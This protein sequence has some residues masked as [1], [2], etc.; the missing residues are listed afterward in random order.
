MKMIARFLKGAQ[1]VCCAGGGYGRQFKAWQGVTQ[2]WSLSP[3]IFNLMVDAVVW[4]WLKNLLHTEVVVNG[5]DEEVH[6]LLACFYT[7]DGRIAC[8]NPDLLQRVFNKLTNLFER[9]RLKTNIKKTEANLC[10]GE[11]LCL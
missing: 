2:G 3:R 11:D 4:E 8:C 6:L 9:C 1:L 7:D 5:I 10:P